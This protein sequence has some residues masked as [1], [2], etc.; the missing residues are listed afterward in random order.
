MMEPTDLSSQKN[1]LPNELPR[2]LIAMLRG[3]EDPVNVISPDYRVIWAN[4][5]VLRHIGRR[6]DQVQGR[7]CYD[8]YFRRTEVCELCPVKEV[9]VSSKACVKEKWIPDPKGSGHWKEVHAYPIHDQSGKVV[10]AIRIGFD[11]TDRKR[12][13]SRRTRYIESLEKAL[14]DVTAG[15][16]QLKRGDDDSREFNLTDRE[17]EVL[18]LMAEGMTNAEIARVLCVSPHTVKSHVVHIF[19]KLGVN[20]RTQ[21]AVKAARLEL[22]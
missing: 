12:R 1:L 11:I 13:Q 10:S 22:I 6:L 20:D 7:L 16:T 14:R 8:L 9:F 21:A 18:G 17:L 15:R 4:G 3:I 2:L 19:N 5:H